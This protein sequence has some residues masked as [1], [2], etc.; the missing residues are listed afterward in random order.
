MP[1]RKNQMSGPQNYFSSSRAQQLVHSRSRRNPRSGE[2]KMPVQSTTAITESMVREIPTPEVP[3]DPS[4]LR[5]VS[6]K[7]AAYRLRKSPDSIYAWLRRGRLRGWQPG[8]HGCQIQVI[9]ASVDEA[10][11]NI[12]GVRGAT[13]ETA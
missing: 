13:S 1:A 2:E 5:M 12:L 8:G 9:E 4:Q 11:K 3:M 6:V 7:E 10:L